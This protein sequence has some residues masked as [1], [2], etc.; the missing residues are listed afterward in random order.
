MSP[1]VRYEQHQ[2]TRVSDRLA[3]C[4][5][6]LFL[7]AQAAPLPP[8]S[9]SDRLKLPTPAALLHAQP[10]SVAAAVSC[11][12]PAAAQS[13]PSAAP[14]AALVPAVFLGQAALVAVKIPPALEHSY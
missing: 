5:P 3:N 14:A 9:E 4:S 12:P 8:L 2:T 6:S 10:V 1:L 13:P 7:A 11:T